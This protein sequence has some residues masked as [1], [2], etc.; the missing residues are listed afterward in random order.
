MQSQ[1]FTVPKNGPSAK[2]AGSVSFERAF[3][4]M[5]ITTLVLVLILV[6][7]A[8]WAPDKQRV[9]SLIDTISTL[10]KM[11]FGALVGLLGGR[12]VK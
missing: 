6:Y 1:R 11:G 7:L 2:G 10:V 3:L 12:A 5:L 4:A 8:C 9:A